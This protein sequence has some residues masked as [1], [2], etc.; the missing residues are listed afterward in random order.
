MEPDLSNLYSN[1]VRPRGRVSMT[2]GGSFGATFE[3]DSKLIQLEQSVFSKINEYTKEPETT[4]KPQ[5]K[6]NDLRVVSVED[7]I[8]ELQMIEASG[9][10]HPPIF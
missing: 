3:R 8:R 7:A 1:A 4:P 2:G 9:I 10:E 5:V 6:T